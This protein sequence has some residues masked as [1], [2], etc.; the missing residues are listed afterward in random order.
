MS[1]LPETNDG[2][3]TSWIPLTAAFTP[4]AGCES[5]FRLNG[6]S[7]VAFDPGY[8]LDIDQRVKCA[9]SAVTTWWEQ[10]RL[11]GGPSEHTAVSIQPLTCPDHWS[12]VV[13]SIKDESSTQAMCCPSGYYL[14]NGVQGSVAGDCF[15]DVKG[16]ET[17][18]YASTE[19]S[20]T[21]V[22]YTRTTTLSASSH[23][24]AI[25]VVGWNVARAATNT[26]PAP[27]PTSTDSAGPDVAATSIAESSTASGLPSTT[28]A[29]TSP[30]SS[31]PSSSSRT[32]SLHSSPQPSPLSSTTLSSETATEALSTSSSTASSSSV[33]SSGVKAGIGLGVSLGVVGVAALV[34]ALIMLCRRSKKT[35][36]DATAP[37]S[38]TEAYPEA[39]PGLPPMYSVEERRQVFELPQRTSRQAAELAGQHSPVELDAGHRRSK[40]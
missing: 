2:E 36:K 15:S 20:A 33:I 32:T 24:G 11:E 25:A 17:L 10:G 26:T 8:G 23:V 14:A 28:P 39:K 40:G 18:T 9:P 19:S 16:G 3:V 29:I 34:M 22:W 21:E 37:E 31:S 7:L 13:T 12:T 38:A 35:W 27:T 4:T 30:L 5:S 6:P 1:V